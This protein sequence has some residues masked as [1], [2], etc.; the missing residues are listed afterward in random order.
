[1]LLTSCG[2]SREFSIA[3]VILADSPYIPSK[4]Y[5]NHKPAATPK[6]GLGCRGAQGLKLRAPARSCSRVDR[7]RPRTGAVA[8]ARGSPSAA[9][10]RPRPHRKAAA[11]ETRYGGQIAICS[12]SPT[13]RAPRR[14]RRRRKGCL[15][16]RSRRAW[17]RC[18]RHRRQRRASCH[19]PRRGGS[20]AR[21]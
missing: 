20:R 9:S 16:W 15:P 13:G 17:S 4:R 11:P 18:G 5:V 6:R 21:P 12:L 10:L 3:T 14:P 2:P 1:M 19:W 7:R 8:A